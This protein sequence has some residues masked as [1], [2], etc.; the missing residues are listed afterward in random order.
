MILQS[1]SWAY[2][3]KK[4]NLKRYMHLCVH[5]ST[6]YNSQDMEAIKVSIDRRMDIEEVVPIR[7]RHSWSVKSSRP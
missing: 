6:I 5:S 3:W 2:V 7:A 4:Y 1:H